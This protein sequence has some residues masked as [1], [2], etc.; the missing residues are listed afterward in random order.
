MAAKTP[1]FISQ[2]SSSL[3]GVSCPLGTPHRGADPR[4]LLQHALENVIRAVSPPA[5]KHIVGGLLPTSEKLMELCE[6]FPLL[7]RQRNWDIY[8]LQEQYGL[9][10]LGDKKISLALTSTS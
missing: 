10:A 3:R 6:E 1:T 2:I 5:N 8:S 7:V 9:K 4:G